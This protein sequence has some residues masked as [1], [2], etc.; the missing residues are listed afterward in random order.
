M[1]TT[2]RRGHTATTFCRR[3]PGK[4]LLASRALRHGREESLN[5]RARSRVRSVMRFWLLLAACSSANSAP[6]VQSHASHAQNVTVAH[7][8]VVAPPVPTRVGDANATGHVIAA[9]IVAA[10]DDAPAS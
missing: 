10:V 1:A 8:P 2:R 9:H 6:P 3:Q 4:T 5:T 7:A